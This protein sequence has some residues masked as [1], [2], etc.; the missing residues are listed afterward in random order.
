VQGR[1]PRTPGRHELQRPEHQ[2]QRGADRMH[3]EGPGRQR[4]AGQVRRQG[5]AGQRI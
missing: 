5:H 3:D 4:E 1:K 2:R